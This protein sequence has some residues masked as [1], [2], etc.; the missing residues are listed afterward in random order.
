MDIMDPELTLDIYRQTLLTFHRFYSELQTRLDAHPSHYPEY[1]FSVKPQLSRLEADL[2]FLGVTAQKPTGPVSF[3]MPEI[4]D[5]SLRMGIFYVIEGSALGGQL[6]TRHIKQ[7]LEITPESG[8]SFFHGSGDQTAQNWKRFLTQLSA[9]DSKIEQHKGVLTGA[10]AT[11]S[12][13]LDLMRAGQSVH[14]GTTSDETRLR[15]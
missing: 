5:D 4:A 15:H 11:F 9:F 2:K 6:I 10:E 3:P 8:G 7:K 14:K 1:N 13:L 12:G